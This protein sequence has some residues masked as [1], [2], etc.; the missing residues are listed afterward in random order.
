MP[1]IIPQFDLSQDEGHVI[2]KLRLPYVKVTKAEFLIEN[3]TLTFYLKPYHLGLTFK[4][5]FKRAEAPK[6]CKYDPSTYILECFVEKFNYGEEFEDLGMIATFM[7]KK[8]AK[9]EKK[10]AKA[11]C[12][13]IEVVAEE[14]NE[15]ELI[16]DITAGVHG[17]SLENKVGFN[18][19]YEDVFDDLEEELWDIA[20]INPKE[21][22]YQVPR[23][24]SIFQEQAQDPR[25]PPSEGVRQGQL[26]LRSL[27]K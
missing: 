15:Q 18:N 12:A 4:Q 16:Q 17:I 27:R 5:L 8:K 23:T 11:K 10:K 22:N 2:I 1:L 19:Q 26:P 13:L 24:P 21:T 6:K 25:P 20:I 14:N 3:D 9:Q 7:Q